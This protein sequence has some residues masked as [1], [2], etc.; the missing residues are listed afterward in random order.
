MWGIGKS[1]QSRFVVVEVIFVGS[2]PTAPPFERTFEE[3]LFS[4]TFECLSTYKR[5]HS[6]DKALGLPGGWMIAIPQG[7]VL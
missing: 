1:G 7:Q 4:E 5:R 2:N 3:V 6:Q